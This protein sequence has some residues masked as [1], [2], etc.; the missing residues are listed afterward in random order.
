MKLKISLTLLTLFLTAGLTFNVP[1]GFRLNKVS[2]PDTLN[3]AYTFWQPPGG[4]FTGMCGNPYSMVFT[5]TLTAMDEP[6]EHHPT[7]RY[8]EAVLYTGQKGVIRI[9]EMLF[10][11][12]PQ[13]ENQKKTGRNYRGETFFSSDC[14]YQSGLMPGDKVIAFVY[15]YEGEYCIPVKSI[16]RIDD[17]RDS[18]VSSVKKYIGSHQDPLSIRSDTAIWK[19][20]RLD[21]ALKT[22]VDCSLSRSGTK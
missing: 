3:V 7:G 14:F 21:E 13:C 17:Y 11:Q 9:A 18:I 12:P 20:Y 10:V 2:N 15:A 8:A 16:L 1:A 19:K 6:V 4:P 22:I 5:G